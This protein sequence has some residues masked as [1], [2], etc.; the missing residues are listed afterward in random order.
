MTGP[1]AST[2]VLALALC[3]ILPALMAM[4]GVEA[5]E[6][7]VEE[8]VTAGTLHFELPAQPLAEALKAYGSMTSLSVLVQSPL[9]ERRT[10]APVAGDYSPRDALERLLAGTGLEARF[11]SAD[12]AIIV[13]PPQSLEPATVASPPAAIAASA[14]DGAM[15]D[16]DYRAY[17]AMVQTRLTEALCDSPQTRP[18]SY[19]LVAQLRIDGTGAVIASRIVGTTGLAARDA[20]IERAMRTLVLDSAPPAALPE[21]VTILLRAHGNGVDTDCTAVD[22][23]G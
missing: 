6:A 21:P 4:Q 23:R 10:S 19:R 3:L 22:E 8:G 12:E 9:L 15:T 7:G 2:A 11:T 5:Q 14:I 13:M 18:G 1:R 16:G 17:A 20:A